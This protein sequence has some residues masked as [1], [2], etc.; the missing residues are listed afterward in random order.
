MHLPHPPGVAMWDMQGGDEVGFGV[1]Q[2]LEGSSATTH[3][4]RHLDTST[5]PTQDV[6]VTWTPRSR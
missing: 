6:P 3:G 5:C 1:Q 4:A 2:G